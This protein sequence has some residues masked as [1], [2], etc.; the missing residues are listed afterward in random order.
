MNTLDIV[1]LLLFIPGIVRGVSKGFIEQAVSLVGIVAAIWAASRFSIK[2]FDWL[3]NYVTSVSDT[4][5]KIIAFALTL[6]AVIIVVILVAKLITGIFK[7]AN[8]GWIN[9][10][11]GFVFAVLLSAV[12]IS[13]VI[14]LFDTINAKFQ[15]VT[16]PVLTESVLYGTLKDLG[17][18]VFPYLKEL[19]GQVQEIATSAA[20][21]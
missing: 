2:V 11:L 7:M 13:I 21:A 9:R 17:Y 15:L 16:S 8:L 10:L 4:V 12:I 1:I 20:A 3:K 18:T 14:I 19:F 6:V 5:L